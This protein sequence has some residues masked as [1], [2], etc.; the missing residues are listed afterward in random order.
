MQLNKSLQTL[1]ASFKQHQQSESEAKIALQTIDRI[2]ASL[3]RLSRQEDLSAQTAL[4]YEIDLGLQK[5]FL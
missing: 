5:L 4:L 3:G 2:K 1:E